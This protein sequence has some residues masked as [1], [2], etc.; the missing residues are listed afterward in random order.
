MET[1]TSTTAIAGSRVELDAFL[2]EE[3]VL[4]AENEESAMNTAFIAEENQ[5]LLTESERDRI[6]LIETSNESTNNRVVSPNLMNSK[7]K[8]ERE[9]DLC[10][11]QEKRQRSSGLNSAEPFSCAL[12]RQYAK[13]L[14]A[15]GDAG[16]NVSEDE[17]ISRSLAR[18]PTTP[19]IIE[20]IPG[21]ESAV[22]TAT[23]ARTPTAPA[24]TT[25]SVQ[26]R[27]YNQSSSGCGKVLPGGGSG[28]GIFAAEVDEFMPWTKGSLLPTEMRRRNSLYD[29]SLEIS[30]TISSNEEENFFLPW[31]DMKEVAAGDT[32]EDRLLGATLIF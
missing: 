17:A 1:K 19:I 5:P 4:V 15:N 6:L 9:I 10:G 27:R 23:I 29:E 21:G 32:V 12:R 25:V 26:K 8:R 3:P 18:R 30:T 7:G 13:F 2:A 28:G 22:A 16:D 24:V 31:L 20:E 11:A 14:V